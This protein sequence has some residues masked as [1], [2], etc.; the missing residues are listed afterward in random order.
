MYGKRS[1]RKNEGNREKT[2]PN[3]VSP[4]PPNA[5]SSFPAFL[6]CGYN[7]DGAV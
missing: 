7:W 4:Q 6:I 2:T 1:H 3:V 5:H